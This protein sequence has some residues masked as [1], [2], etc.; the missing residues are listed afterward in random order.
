MK[1]INSSYHFFELT[2]ATLSNSKNKSLEN[3]IQTYLF[4]DKYPWLYMIKR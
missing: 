2:S 3:D 4:S 1:T